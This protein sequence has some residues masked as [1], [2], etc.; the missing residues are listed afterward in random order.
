MKK[1]I[2]LAALALLS[3]V[4]L[5]EE[6]ALNTI[7]AITGKKYSFQYIIGGGELYFNKN[8]TYKISYSS[9]G[10]YWEDAGTFQLQKGKIY[11]KPQQ[12]SP[13][14]K[15]E[16]S[17]YTMTMGDGV[18]TLSKSDDTLDYLYSIKCVSTYNKKNLWGSNSGNDAMT[19][20]DETSRLPAGSARN[21]KNVPVITMG[22]KKGTTTTNVKI[23][24]KPSTKAKS[25]K[26][27]RGIYGDDSELKD[28]VP[29]GTE[30]TVI[31]R[32]VGREKVET[33]NNYWYYV[34]VGTHVGMDDGVWV[35]G[36]FV[37]FRD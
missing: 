4:I 13:A 35:Y 10:W 2:L 33:W 36:E 31:A 22:M 18:C 20:N 17:H 25:L 19:F 9:E 16:K 37:K 7:D 28:F 11:L 29:A 8:N 24:E 5:A 3:P 27:S 21:I 23:R 32:T 30:L 12:C 1:L 34:N 14:D 15:D 6:I 26:F